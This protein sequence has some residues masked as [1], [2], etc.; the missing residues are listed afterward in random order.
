MNFVRN[1]VSPPLIVS[2]GET[3][4]AAVLFSFNVDHSLEPWYHYQPQH[5]TWALD[6]IKQE[7]KM[8]SILH[9]YKT[10]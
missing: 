5:Q 7:S 4:L 8:I 10:T 3:P 9:K 2:L 6:T 1:E